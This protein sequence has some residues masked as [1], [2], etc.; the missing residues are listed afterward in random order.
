MVVH[1]GVERIGEDGL[2]WILSRCSLG[3]WRLSNFVLDQ[4]V[5]RRITM[6]L[7]SLDPDEEKF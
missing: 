3:Y 4:I 6:L 5:S 1:I 2:A 7:P